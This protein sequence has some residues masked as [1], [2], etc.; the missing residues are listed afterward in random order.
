MATYDVHQHL[1]PESFIAA[2]E[3][4]DRPPFLTGSELVTS[5]RTSSVTTAVSVSAAP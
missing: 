3:A 5:E 2:L 1:W 4:R